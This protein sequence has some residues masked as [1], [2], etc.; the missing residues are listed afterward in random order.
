MSEKIAIIT[1][2]NSGISQKDAKE[3]GITVIPMP[4]IINGSEFFEDINLTVEQ[5]Y[6][7]LKG[8]AEVSTS[9]PT[10]ATVLD[11]WDELLK[12]HDTI[13]HIPMSSGL[14]G[15]CATATALALDYENKVFVVDNQRISVTLLASVFEAKRMADEGRTAAEIKKH[16]VDTRF[17]S[18]IYIMLD[19]LSYLKKG[20]RVTPA[21]EMIAT[22]LRIKPVLKLQGEKLDAFAKARS[23]KQGRLI[24]IDAMKADIDS[25]LGGIENVRLYIAHTDNIDAATEFAGEVEEAFGIKPLITAELSLSVSCHIGPGSLALACAVK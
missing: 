2:S 9:Q 8:G 17:D 21:A 1:D 16:L 12:T 11:L 15:S 4:F 7:K 24:M 20:G 18:S 5:F 19:T 13:L 3:L 23:E 22:V 14:S 10:V 6:E 25:R